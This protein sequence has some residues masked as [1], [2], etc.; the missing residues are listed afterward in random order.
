MGSQEAKHKIYPT[1]HCKSMTKKFYVES[2]GCTMNQGETG[3]LAEFMEDNGHIQVE[4]LEDADISLLGTCV[5]IKKTEERM[6]R[7]VKE[8]TQKTSE[9]IIAGCLASIRKKEL[10]SKYSNV[11]FINPE[12]VDLSTCPK[13]D[14]E[15][16]F[17]GT[18]P[19]A[20][21]CKGSCTYCITK[22]ARGKIQ[23]RPIDKIKERFKGLVKQSTREIRLTSQDMAIYGKDRS[24]DLIELLKTLLEVKGDYRIRLGMMNIDGLAS[25]KDDLKDIM[26]DDRIYKFIHLPLQSGSDDVLEKMNRSYSVREWIETAE[27]FRK[28]FPDLTLSTD[29]IVGFPG[30]TEEDFSMTKEALTSIKPD[31]INVT[32]FSPRK[33]TRAAE[34]KEKVESQEKKRRSKEMTELR[35][36]IS[37]DLNDDYVGRKAWATILER[38]KGTSLKGRL[39]NYKVIVLK[40]E[41]S[42][43]LGKRKEVKI[44]AAEHVYLLADLIE[45]KS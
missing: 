25:I 9:V 36:K 41:T 1:Y 38:G 26:K 29:I 45:S 27:E 42:N 13:K 16:P 44:K 24:T 34:M 15:S 2:Y 35:F 5:V 43:L 21:G 28:Q 22:S 3:M 31:I 12:Q 19:I 17:V 23:S 10:Q 7:R 8:L 4:N 33:G 39:D 18:I 40:D 37:R 30:E 14:E 20:S 6:R 32:R 11:S